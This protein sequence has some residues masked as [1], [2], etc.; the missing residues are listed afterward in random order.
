MLVKVLEEKPSKAG[1]ALVLSEKSRKNLE[2]LLEDYYKKK[3]AILEDRYTAFKEDPVSLFEMA[4]QPINIEKH[5]ITIAPVMDPTKIPTEF[6]C[7]ICGEPQYVHFYTT[8]TGKE[9]YVSSCLEVA[10]NPKCINLKRIKED[11]SFVYTTDKF[12]AQDFST[13]LYTLYV[14]GNQ[15][16]MWAPASFGKSLTQTVAQDVCGYFDKF[17]KVK[18]INVKVIKENQLLFDKNE[19]YLKE[20]GYPMFEISPKS[21]VLP[22]KEDIERYNMLISHYNMW[23][24]EKIHQQLGVQKK[25]CPPLKRL[26]GF[27]SFPIVETKKEEEM[28]EKAVEWIIETLNSYEETAKNYWS[29]LSV[30]KFEALLER[31]KPYSEKKGKT[32]RGIEQVYTN[33][34]SISY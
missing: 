12:K 23:L 28:Q 13:K 21:D 3:T 16:G 11:N 2:T 29:G 6:S 5:A 31:Y 8:D 27:P 25:D 26:K 15:L 33:S 32:K 1:E 34:Q 14:K 10:H 24:N 9:R 30:E 20:N 4:S 19:G 7:K 17:N 18:G 22:N